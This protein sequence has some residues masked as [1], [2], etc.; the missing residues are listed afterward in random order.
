MLRLFQGVLGLTVM[1]VL[2]AVIFG[3]WFWMII[4]TVNY[5]G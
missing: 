3:T 1:Y 2:S 4:R 5:L